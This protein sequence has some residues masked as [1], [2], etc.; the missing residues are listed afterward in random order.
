MRIGIDARFYGSVGKGLG[1]YAQKLIENLEKIDKENQ[2]FIF[3]LKENFDEFQPKNKNFK[4]VLADYRWYTFS[5]QINMPKLLNR[6]NLDIVHFP[7]FNVPLFYR[8]KFIITIHDLILLHFPTLKNTTLN[9]IF[10]WIKFMAYKLAIG[11]AIR[12]SKK[13]ITVSR[14]SKNDILA[15][16]AFLKK[17]KIAVTYEACDFKKETEPATKNNGDILRKYGIIRPYLI[18]VG[19]AYPHKNLDRLVDS[20]KIFSTKIRN[21]KKFTKVPYLVL[22]GKRD[23]FYNKLL[24]KIKKDNIRNIISTG[25]VEDSDLKFI[26]EKAEAYVFPSLYEGFGLPPL[27]AMERGLPVASNGH[28][29]MREILGKSAY[30]FDGKKTDSIIETMEKM[31]LDSELKKDLVRRGRKQIL[32]YS[33]KKM[34]QQTKNIYNEI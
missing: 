33:W 10:Y 11:N 30:Y 22:V 32:K 13:I 18:Y 5:E 31:F 15:K 26:Y 23:Y 14:F 7:H 9:P 4:K 29:C 6:Y 27:E 34:A 28:G 21:G 3:L 17:D 1:R 24:K 16:Y 2:Y 12:R 8:K 25:F 20:W 19:N